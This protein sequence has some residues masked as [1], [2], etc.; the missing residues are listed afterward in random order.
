MVDATIPRV[1]DAIWRVWA[2]PGPPDRPRGRSADPSASRAQAAADA[3]SIG[4][5]LT[6][7]PRAASSR[8]E[9]ERSR[10]IN[11]LAATVRIVRGRVAIV[12]LLVTLPAVATA[13]V[14]PALV[15]TPRAD[16]LLGRDGPDR[17]DA[18]SGDD[19]IAV[20]YDA[21]PDVVSCGPGRDVVTADLRDSVRTDC[22]IVG[23]RIH[24]DRFTNA[25]S[26][27]ESEVEPDSLT[28]GATTV[29]LFQV[30]RNRSGGAASIGF[31]T[32]KDGGRTWREGILPGLTAVSKPVGPSARA[33]DPVLAY[34]A[35][36]GVWLANTLALAP[37]VN[38]LTIHRSTNGL[39]WSGP[40]DA[41]IAQTEELA[42]DKNWLACDNGAAS[43]FRG[44][45]LP[46]LHADRR[47]HRPTR[48][49][50]LRRRRPHMVCSGDAAASRSRASSPSSSPTASFC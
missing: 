6:P 16:V 4:N 7:R 46:R 9:T 15:G 39:T 30:G 11:H 20:E 2:A 10:G 36:H 47:P 44:A 1:R 42:Y 41:A 27:H 18:R 21:G 22:E 35:A 25:D 3:T 13:A 34:D 24:R 26:Q 40:M 19:R 8:P 48:R 12:L 17:V 14:R 28:V 43:P 31:S 29:A 50:A 38:R 23:R 37:G 49:A 45:L 5:G 32:S 33:S